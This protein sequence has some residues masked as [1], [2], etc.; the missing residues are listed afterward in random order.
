LILNPL[1]IRPGALGDAVL[2]L[3]VLSALK[4]SGAQ[5]VT[6]LGTP[7]SWAFLSGEDKFIT[8]RDFGSRAWLGLFADGAEFSP[9]AE[10]TLARTDM[11]IVYLAGDAQSIQR[12]LMKFCKKVL[13][14]E[15]P[16]AMNCG[17][18]NGTVNDA[19]GFGIQPCH[20]SRRL[21][22]PLSA[23]LECEKVRDALLPENGIRDGWAAPAL[24][25]IARAK[26]SLQPLLKERS[27]F[28]ALH[29]GSGGQKKCWP[30]LRYAE[31]A[32]QLFERQNVVPLVFFGAADDVVRAQFAAA[33]PPGVAWQAIDRRPLREVLALL[34]LCRLFV[35][36]DSG[37]SHLAAQVTP[38]LAIFGPT[39]P[40]AWKPI[41]QRVSVLGARN[42][43]LEVLAVDRVY[44]RAETM[45]L[46]KVWTPES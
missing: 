13:L 30:A 42:G 28:V 4:A 44:S 36:N 24:A 26:Q 39:A 34:S 9:D 2:T 20:A 7:A 17:A 6:I 11:A 5:H 1:V 27:G 23:I 22:D 15:A 3:P 43:I 14:V 29:P 19:D 18:P 31:L 16:T 46:E 10:A 38:V 40:E 45:L 33:I 35:G 37:L 32:R 25:E 21:L 8:V 41:G 12:R